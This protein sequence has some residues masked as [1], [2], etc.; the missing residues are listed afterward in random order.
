MKCFRWSHLA[1]GG[2][3]PR[4]SSTSGTTLL[5]TFWSSG[6]CRHAFVS[7]LLCFSTSCLS[8]FG[9]AAGFAFYVTLAALA[10]Q[11]LVTSFTAAGFI[12]S[13]I[14]PAVDFF[15]SCRVYF[16]LYPPSSWRLLLQLQ[17][18]FLALSTQQLTSFTAAGFTFSF[19][20]PAVGDFFYSCRVY[21]Q[22]YSLSSWWQPLTTT[23]FTSFL[24]TQPL[25]I[26]LAIHAS[27][28]W[29]LL[30]L[31]LQ[32][33][34]TFTFTLAAVVTTFYSYWGYF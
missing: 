27:I 18:L 4:K 28:W 26:P 30:V 6:W 19:I 15:Y 11:Q 9:T 7:Y 17:G 3:R 29:C 1:C 8:S 32:S 12:F 31:Q 20:H 34:L 13:F 21:F 10:T 22:L 33:L 2:S 16:Q 14:H 25:M 23:E 24:F 5:I